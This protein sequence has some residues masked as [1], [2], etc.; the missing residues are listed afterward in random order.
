MSACLRQCFCYLINCEGDVMSLFSTHSDRVASLQFG[1]GVEPEY[2]LI[3]T[4][5]LVLDLELS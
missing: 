2:D 4:L 1:L 5:D 3:T